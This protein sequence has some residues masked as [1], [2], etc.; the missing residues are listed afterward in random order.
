MQNII[1]YISRVPVPQLDVRADWSSPLA[2]P[3]ILLDFVYGA[4]AVKR[5]AVNDVHQMMT[6]RHVAAFSHIPP[7]PYSPPTSD[8]EE[9]IESNDM[10]DPDCKAPGGWISP[11]HRSK[12]SE[13]SR[14]MDFAFHFSMYLKGY[15]PGTT[16]A[17]FRQKQEE[18]A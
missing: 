11:Y 4:A 16:L 9:D 7:Y 3:S 6:E 10:G 14:A 15:P 1:P 2:P 13:L 5:W 18:E 12:E 17:M 8:D